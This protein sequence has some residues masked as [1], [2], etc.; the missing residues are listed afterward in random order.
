M[1]T[2]MKK[3]VIKTVAYMTLV[4]P[5]VFISST[6]YALY[7]LRTTVEV[8]GSLFLLLLVAIILGFLHPI[9]RWVISTR[10][11]KKI[12]KIQRSLLKRVK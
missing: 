5:T 4:V 3:S 8:V 2:T 1:K 9:E 12:V 6:T 7:G 10:L 11:F